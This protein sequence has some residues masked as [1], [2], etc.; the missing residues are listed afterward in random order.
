[1]GE[2]EASESSESLS[3][4]AGESLKHNSDTESVRTPRGSSGIGLSGCDV[5]DAG[6]SCKELFRRE[7]TSK[8]VV[9]EGIMVVAKCVCTM[10][11]DG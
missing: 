5:D 4:E 1:M 10:V 3:R 2:F 8:L 6:I 9:V 11:D 7:L